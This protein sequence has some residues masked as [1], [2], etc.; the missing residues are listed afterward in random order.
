MPV[1]QQQTLRRLAPLATERDFFLGGG[2]ALATQLGH[3]RSVDLGWFTAGKIADP[4]GLA[5]EL[6]RSG[7]GFDVTGIEKGTLHGEANGV[8][9]SFL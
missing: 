6:R 8:K 9:V 4:L 7:V 5:M 2:T 3:R 1:T